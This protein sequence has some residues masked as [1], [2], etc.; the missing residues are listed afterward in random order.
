MA[1]DLQAGHHEYSQTRRVRGPD[2]LELV[3]VAFISLAVLATATA[4]I[5]SH[6][7]VVQTTEAYSV[8][9]AV[10]PDMVVAHSLYGKWPGSDDATLA[11]VAAQATGHYTHSASIGTDHTIV[12]RLG[13]AGG[14]A[15]EKQAIPH[16]RRLAFRP[17]LLGVPGA[18]SVM[19]LCGHAPTPT[20][21]RTVFGADTTTVHTNDLPPGCRKDW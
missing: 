1:S 16:E 8:A 19:F 18:E 3:A 20:G 21:E 7:H 10:E 5:P 13:G 11:K 6:I 4:F 2:A 9:A 17:V 12:V 14:T 15:G